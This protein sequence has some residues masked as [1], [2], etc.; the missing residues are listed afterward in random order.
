MAIFRKYY[1]IIFLFL[2]FFAITLYSNPFDGER[3]YK[4]NIIGNKR[5]ERD[6]IY[7]Y[8]SVKPGDIFDINKIRKDVKNIYRM[9][10]FENVL[11]NYHKLKQGIEITYIVVE[12]P[13]IGFINFK[14]IKK[15]KKSKITKE[16]KVKPFTVLNEELLKKDIQKIIDIYQENGYYNVK[17]KYKISKPRHNRVTIDIIINE[18]EKSKIKKVKFIGNK[19]ISS[20]KIQKHI[21]TRPYNFLLSWVT[22]T[23]YLK[24]S[25]LEKDVKRIE[26]YYFT[27][28]YVRAKVFD[29]VVKVLKDGKYLTVTFKI[30]EGKRYKFSKVDII[31]NKLTPELRKKFSENLECKAGDYFSNKKIH[32]DIQYLTDAY[33]DLGYAFADVNPITRID[34]DNLTVSVDFKVERGNLYKFREIHISGNTYT[35][36]KVIRRK[37]RVY[38]QD[39]YTVSGLKRSRVLLKRTGYFSEVDITTKK[40]SDNQIDV[41]VMVKE[42]QTGSFTIGGGYSS[43]NNFIFTGSLSKNNLFG[44]GYNANFYVN[45]SSDYSRY[46]ISFEDPAFLDSKVSTGYSLYSI[47]TEYDSYD[48][49]SKGF[50]LTV[51]APFNDFS[52]WKAGY[53]WEKVKVYNV[54]EYAAQYIKDEEGTRSSGGITLSLNKNT[55]DDYYYPTKGVIQSISSVISGPIFGGDESFYKLIGE[56]RW[57]KRI[58]GNVVFAFHLKLGYID[59]YGGKKIPSWEKFYV[60]GINSLRGFKFGKAGPRDEVGDVKGADKEI[61]TNTEIRFPILEELGVRGVVFFD[62]GKGYDE[63]EFDF[64]LRK[65][66]G[67]GLS[68]RS[69]F[70]PVVVYWGKNLSLKEDEK[71]SVFHFSMGKTF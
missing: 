15:I 25:E 49:L 19:H 62:M 35:R 1:K 30:E 34:D 46:N 5:I 44:K 9:G 28:G 45:L 67:A 31:D 39:R 29:P 60:G 42:Q 17:V 3:V 27:Q 68:W 11:V 69:P 61:I 53:F 14:G 41:N 50:S 66:V 43:A 47:D 70:G 2:F 48:T 10:Y 71:S 7:P 22:G 65:S 23:G 38:E 55:T 33:G 59:S 13:Y 56:S 18:G 32:D 63:G 52:G 37:L 26:N 6:A 54:D 21:Y 64:D 36:D 40:V 16:L 4:V 20:S 24:K 8:I 58:K 57:F 51:G 12:K